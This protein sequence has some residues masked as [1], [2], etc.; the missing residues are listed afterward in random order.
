M[1]SIVK[2]GLV[3]EVRNEEEKS[4]RAS[5]GVCGVRTWSGTSDR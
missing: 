3:K 1:D 4:E 2:E 5:E